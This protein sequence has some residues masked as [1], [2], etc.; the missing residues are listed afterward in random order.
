M[1]IPFTPDDSLPPRPGG[2]RAPRRQPILSH[3]LA[4]RWFEELDDAFSQPAIPEAGPY[5]ASMANSRCNRQLAYQL[6]G[7]ERTNP[8]T[9]ADAWRMNI[10]TMVHDGLMDTLRRLDP[11]SQADLATDLRAIGIP[12]SGR[13]DQLVDVEN[14]TTGKI[15]KTAAEYKTVNGFKFKKQA[16]DFSGPPEGPSYGAMVQGATTALVHDADVLIVASLSLENLSPA[17]LSKLGGGTEIDRFVAEWSLPR[18]GIELLAEGERDRVAEVLPVALEDPKKVPRTLVDLD[19]AAGTVVVSPNNG[20][21]VTYDAD[22]ETVIGTGK[23]WYCDYCS[24][25]DRCIEDGA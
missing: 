21:T 20:A 13:L 1:P 9:V 24:F 17:M 10:G 2:E 3:L 4:Q 12:G 19:H 11:T 22:G 25:R 5:R 16:T 15:T 7:T 8:M 23:T 6:A 18:S 14:T